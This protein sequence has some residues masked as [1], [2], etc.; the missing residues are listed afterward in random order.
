MI[1]SNDDKAVSL[2]IGDLDPQWDESFL[3]ELFK[4][5]FPEV[6]GVKIIRDRLTGN[7]LCL[8]LTFNYIYL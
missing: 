4:P 3:M 7:S 8:L 2:Y 5:M 6:I 1:D